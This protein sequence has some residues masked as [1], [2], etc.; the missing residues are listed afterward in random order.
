[1][2]DIL[3]KEVRTGGGGGGTLSLKHI[4]AI[5]FSPN[6]ICSLRSPFDR[7]T[8]PYGEADVEWIGKGEE[9]GMDRIVMIVQRAQK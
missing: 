7:H 3:V 9:S 1:M 4:S 2:K 6:F 5:N 8:Q